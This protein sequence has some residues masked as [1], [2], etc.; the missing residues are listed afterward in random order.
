MKKLFLGAA[1]LLFA[2][3]LF[4]QNT[5]FS[6]Q[7]GDDQ[8]VYVRQAGTLLSS[9]II[10]ANGTGNGSHRAMVIQK[11]DGNFSA[12]D[13][14]G[15]NNQAYVDQGAE[16]TPPINAS[17]IIN[18]GKNN[19]TSADNKARVR[20][21]GG[22][23]SVA[24]INQDGDENEA[25]T[26]QDGTSGIVN[27][28]QDGTANK[29]YVAQ[30]PYYSALGNV[31]NII[32]TGL[33]NCSNA[34]QDGDYNTLS[35]TQSGSENKADQT[36]SGNNN[37]ANLTQSGTN[38]KA[39]QVQVGNNNINNLVFQ[40]G[41]GNYSED[42]QIG[43]SNEIFK[44]QQGADNYGRIDQTGDNNYTSFGQ[45]GTNSK[46]YVRQIGNGNNMIMG[47]FVGDGNLAA[48]YQDDN[49]I[50][51]TQQWGNNNQALLVQKSQGGA[52]HNGQIWQSGN[53]NMADVLQLGPGGDFNADA[54]D[55]FFPDPVEL[56]CPPPLPEVI[57]GAP[58]E[59]CPN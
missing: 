31:A 21:H 15:T 59:G 45:Y 47:Q 46:G 20:Q 17:S 19:T 55:C 57:I 50:G 16:F 28:T 44:G 33:Y 53:G 7:T 4:A 54:E 24:T 40:T 3:G 23:G 29:S 35:A 34:A 27:I 22:T 5:S 51:V 41:S 48:S 43:N 6:S 13:Q 25:A 37:L 12:I 26:H 30:L 18:Q 49:N 2:G 56:N 32:Q 39:K 8:R 9:N 10:Q 1:A 36:Q 38:G 14:E 42:N 52:G 58:C 11:G